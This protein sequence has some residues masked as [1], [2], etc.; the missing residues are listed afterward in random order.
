MPRPAVPTQ[1]KIT[2]AALAVIDRDGLSALTRPHG[3]RP[4]TTPQASL[5]AVD[6]IFAPPYRAFDAGLRPHPFQMKP[7]ACYRATWQLP[8]PDSHR[9]ATTNLRTANPPP[10]ATSRSAG[11]TKPRG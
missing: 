11:R 1:E 10:Q 4:L 7:P 8:G 3:Q 6:R 2:A 5:H 9:Q